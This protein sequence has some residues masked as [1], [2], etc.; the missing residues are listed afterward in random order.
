[1]SATLAHATERVKLLTAPSSMH[2]RITLEREAEKGRRDGKGNFRP[3][4]FLSVSE[5]S[6][7]RSANEKGPSRVIIQRRRARPLHEGL[8]YHGKDSY[9]KY[10]LPLVEYPLSN[11]T[12][13]SAAHTSDETICFDTFYPWCFL[14]NH[15]IYH[16]LASFSDT[17]RRFRRVVERY[18]MIG[19]NCADSFLPRVIAYCSNAI[20]GVIK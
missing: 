9:S 17:V 13:E 12:N 4:K 5:E 14:H 18:L 8:P 19:A 7:M 1:M 3:Q 20:A 10:V 15:R 6:R 16:H 2:M 11:W